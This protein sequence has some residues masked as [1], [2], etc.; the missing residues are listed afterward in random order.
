[1]QFILQIKNKIIITLR[2]IRLRDCSIIVLAKSDSTYLAGISPCFML[3][4]NI[5][6]L[7]RLGVKYEVTYYNIRS[8]SPLITQVHLLPQQSTSAPV[9]RTCYG[10]PM[11]SSLCAH[12]Y[13]CSLG[14]VGCGEAGCFVFFIFHLF[15]PIFF[16]CSLHNSNTILYSK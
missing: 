7:V 13:G 5:A 14:Q 1:M 8:D 4:P 9:T 2:V 6:M 3:C 11:C 12:L 16:L 10:Y 15:F